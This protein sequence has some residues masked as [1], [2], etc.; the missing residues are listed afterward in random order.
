MIEHFAP[1]TGLADVSRS[2][3][4]QYWLEEK[5]QI[6]ANQWYLSERAGHDVGWEYAQHHWLT[7][8]RA[9]WVAEGRPTGTT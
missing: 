3:Y 6:A 9:R 4:L 8:H 2:S 1:P 7:H 5:R